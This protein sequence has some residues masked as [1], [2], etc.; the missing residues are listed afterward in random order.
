M[1]QW[2]GK[3]LTEL[4]SNDFSHFIGSHAGVRP[5][6]PVKPGLL[7]CLLTLCMLAGCQTVYQCKTDQGTVEQDKPCPTIMG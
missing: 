4:F 7:V 1:V 5:G 6:L 2:A 3:I